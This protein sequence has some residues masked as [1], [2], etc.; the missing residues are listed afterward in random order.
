MDFYPRERTDRAAKKGRDGKDPRPE[1]EDWR[2]GDQRRFEERR[3]SE[4]RL[5]FYTP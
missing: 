4:E 5:L 3:R 2:I 1:L